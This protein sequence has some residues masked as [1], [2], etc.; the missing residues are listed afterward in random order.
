[1][2]HIVGVEEANEHRR[3]NDDGHTSYHIIEG[4]GVGQGIAA[5]WGHHAN[6]AVQHG[7]RYRE[8]RYASSPRLRRR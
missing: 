4:F 6:Q 8:G 7:S 2:P 5:N 3:I 1:M